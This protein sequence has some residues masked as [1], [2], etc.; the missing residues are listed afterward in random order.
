MQDK[1]TYCKKQKYCP[2]SKFD[3]WV[4]VI[5]SQHQCLIESYGTYESSDVTPVYL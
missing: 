5:D 2:A 4:T 3:C 1:K